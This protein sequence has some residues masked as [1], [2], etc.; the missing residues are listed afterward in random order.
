MRL[1][2]HAVRLPGGAAGHRD[3][4]DPRA[5]DDEHDHRDRDRLRADLRPGDP[6]QR[7]RR[8]RGGLRP[9]LPLGRRLGLPPAHPARAAQRRA[10]DHRADLG[11]PRVRRPGRGGAVLP[12]PGHPAAEPVLGADARR[13]ARVHRA[14]L[15]A[16]V[17]PGH[18]DRGHGALLQPA[19]RRAARR[20]RPAA[21]DA[22]AGVAGDGAGA[23]GRRPAGAAAHARG[24][25]AHVVERAV[26]TRVGAG[27]DASPSW[28]SPA[29]A[30]ASRCW[31]LLGLLPAAGRPPSPARALLAGRGPAG[32]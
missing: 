11:E 20:P 8:P 18:G 28:G 10:A 32:A 16:G 12:G 27:R 7:A 23:R 5:R 14:G 29:A 6:R 15:V 2:G 13:G 3:P 26:A 24:G 9:R 19:R 1:H 31:P 4:G 25:T 22:E 17:L 21:A 30:R